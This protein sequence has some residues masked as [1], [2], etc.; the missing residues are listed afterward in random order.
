MLLSF[1]LRNS[2]GTS[3]YF[4]LHLN[5]CMVTIY[6]SSLPNANFLKFEGLVTY[7]GHVGFEEAGKVLASL[8]TNESSFRDLPELQDT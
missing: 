3:S 8:T 5:P 6:S 7:M 4:R 1:P 2:K